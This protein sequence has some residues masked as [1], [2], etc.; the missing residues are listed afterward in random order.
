MTLTLLVHFSPEAVLGIGAGH[1]IQFFP[2][3]QESLV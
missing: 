1:R 2:S 3:G